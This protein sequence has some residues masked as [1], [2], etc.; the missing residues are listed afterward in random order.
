MKMAR[1][2]KAGCA[3][4]LVLMFA[5]LI[6]MPDI[7]YGAVAIDTEKN[8]TI[9]F[10]VSGTAFTELTGEEGLSVTI[11]LYRVASV[12][13]NGRFT[14][15]ASY[16][17]A[18]SGLDIV[19][20]KTSADTW[21]SMAEEAAQV[22]EPKTEDGTPLEGAQTPDWTTELIEG[23]GQIT[24]SDSNPLLPGL[25]LVL[26]QPS[27]SAAYR[28]TFQPY[29]VALPGNSYYETGE[30]TW[31]YQV[32]VGLK[33][34]QENRLGSLII[35]KTI[36]AYEPRSAS[37][38]TMFVFEVEVRKTEETAAGT[39]DRL[40][41][42]NVVSIGFD[43]AGTKTFEIPNLPA[44]AVATVT[45][46]YSGTSYNIPADEATVQSEPVVAG[47]QV[48]VSF[49]NHYNG[50]LNGGSGVVN[51]FEHDGNTW[52]WNQTAPQ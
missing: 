37:D 38:Q 30:D 18:L 28:Y 39:E 6:A 11:H 14:A 8:G 29:L 31:L 13:E 26:A 7:V 41:Y 27:E 40:Y 43:A 19:D 49:N 46:V 33:P 32:T 1:K 2:I 45:E 47:S 24:G 48:N 36:D 3:L 25:Y 20:A 51:H 10:E 52:N 17:D 50:G 34:E 12:D 42:S 5:L 16:A 23:S 22:A 15:E 35:S 44:G 21:L 4:A 9:D